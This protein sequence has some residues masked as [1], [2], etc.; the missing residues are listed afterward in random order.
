MVKLVISDLD[1]GHQAPLE[2]GLLPVVIQTTDHEIVEW[3]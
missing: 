2:A 1:T 3:R